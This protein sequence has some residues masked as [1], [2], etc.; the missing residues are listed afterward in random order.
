MVQ[1]K[2]E[3]DGE[4]SS[5]FLDKARDSEN[6]VSSL[7]R[8]L[9]RKLSCGQTLDQYDC[10]FGIRLDAQGDV[11]LMSDESEISSLNEEDVG[12]L[13]EQYENVQKHEVSDEV[14]LQREQQICE[15]E[16]ILRLEEA[17]LLM[18]K[19]L[20]HSQLLHDEKKLEN[21]SSAANFR[22]LAALQNSS[23]QA[24][25]PKVA[26]AQH[27]QHQ[28]EK[29]QT[30]EFIDQGNQH[31][32]HTSS[33]ISSS[34][35]NG[36]E[37]FQHVT[38]DK[39]GVTAS[40]VSVDPASGMQS[41]VGA[42]NAGV[43]QLS[44]LLPQHLQIIQQ[45]YERFSQNTQLMGNL[46][47]TLPPHTGH[48]LAELLRQYA[49]AHSTSATSQQSTKSS[50]PQKLQQSTTATS[51][52]SQSQLDSSNK[53][54]RELTQQNIV[55]AR[56]QIRRELDQLVTK[57][58]VPKAPLP[59]LSFIPNGGSNQPEFVYL[60]GLDLTVQRVLK[61]RQMFKKSDIPPYRCE[62]CDTDFTPSW[63]AICSDNEDH[64]LYCERCVRLAQK[65]K[66][67]LDYKGLLYRAFQQIKEREKSIQH[68]TTCQQPT[69]LNLCKSAVTTNV[70][71]AM[72]NSVKSSPQ[73]YTKGSC[74]TSASTSSKRGVTNIRVAS[75]NNTLS[76]TASNTP[77]ASIASNAA[78][79]VQNPL[80][81]LQQ[82]PLF[83][84]QIAAMTA[85]S[86]TPIMR[87][88]GQIATNPVLLA[89]ITQNPMILQQVFAAMTAQHQQQQRAQPTSIAPTA[90]VNAPS[91]AAAT[92]VHLAQKSQIQQHHRTSNT[93]TS[94]SATHSSSQHSASNAGMGLSAVSNQQ[95][96]SVPLALA[97]AMN[98]TAPLLHITQNQ[99]LF[100]NLSAL[101]QFRQMMQMYAQQI[102]GA[103]ST[104][105]SGNV[106]K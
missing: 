47:K 86:N 24:Y 46:L 60:L 1:E 30:L 77:T 62:E 59:D 69:A 104:S 34:K 83:Q 68:P 87:N 21:G 75:N 11:V 51:L 90:T 91:G 89:A 84:Q 12:R 33:S 20:R 7:K 98:S 52:A 72:A 94:S 97:A 23:G 88:L 101:P 58:P 6:R 66:V 65:R 105:S 63:K 100:N 39:K 55:K 99:Q 95:Q 8:K 14:Q 50:L 5:P 43:I 67:C 38:S 25:K 102:K 85:L 80:S 82:N 28:K 22:R 103:T 61:D 37:A 17:K 35:L 53:Q 18:I 93:A 96:Q 78:S 15:L 29:S 45:L 106:K 81:A 71:N 26:V 54:A 92:L 13:R 64:H 40:K 9:K 44:S 76:T 41:L 32:S 4:I 36:S 2:S 10:K 16:A 31:K 70:S 79:A 49:T 57:L 27:Q 56:Q 48:A 3:N 19:K 74:N 42:A 73:N